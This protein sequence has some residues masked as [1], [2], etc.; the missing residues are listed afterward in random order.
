MS[1][2]NQPPSG[3]PAPGAGHPAPSAGHSA[4]SAGDSA[5]SEGAAPQGGARPPAKLNLPTRLSDQIPGLHD[6]QPNTGLRHGESGALRSSDRDRRETRKIRTLMASVAIFIVTVVGAVV[7]AGSHSQPT[8]AERLAWNKEEITQIQHSMLAITPA[9]YHAALQRPEVAGSSEKAIRALVEE[10]IQRTQARVAKQL[11]STQYQ[12]NAAEWARNRRMNFILD[13]IGSWVDG[14]DRPFHTDVK[15]LHL[16]AISY[17][18]NGHRDTEADPAGDDL[19]A[20]VDMPSGEPEKVPLWSE[21]FKLPD[22]SKVPVIDYCDPKY[23]DQLRARDPDH[24]TPRERKMEDQE[25]VQN[26]IDAGYFGPDLQAKLN[27]CALK[28]ESPDSIF[29]N[30][31]KIPRA[32]SAR[33]P[34]PPAAAAAADNAPVGPAAPHP[35]P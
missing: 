33:S 14:Y 5:R 3:D 22:M 2:A 12:S 25:E 28:G 35:A 26:I 11:D 23:M 17:G 6:Y 19:V 7:L 32:P 18:A 16:S 29:K 8:P 10:N 13:R 31:A 30:G 21:I 4:P 24:L 27:E 9:E 20:S 34:E 1:S 15:G